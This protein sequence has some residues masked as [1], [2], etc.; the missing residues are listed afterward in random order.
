MS[1]PTREDILR[2]LELLPVWRPRDAMLNES[3]NAH[4]VAPKNN[5]IPNTPEL[6]AADVVTE[7]TES[8][9][10]NQQL[11]PIKSDELSP[12]ITLP[13][14]ADVL[15]VPDRADVIESMD[16]LTLQNSIKHCDACALSET[17]TQIVFGTGDLKAEWMFIGDAPSEIDGLRGEPF[18]DQAG[19][20]LDNML[21][22]MQ[23]RRGQNVYITNVLK[24]RPSGNL[25]PKANEV[26]QCLPYLK[27]QV[28]LVK[29]K[30]IIALGQFAAQSLLQTVDSLSSLR[31]R[32][33]RYN[34]IPLIVTFHPLDLLSRL[35]DKPK[36]WDDLCLA[37]QTMQAQQTIQD[38]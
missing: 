12:E 2:E 10:I 4:P 19:K 27:Q 3:A 17:P 20:L 8:L 18:V 1:S 21:I 9:E 24:C 16:W 13:L 14:M 11:V 30:I 34:D 29:P 38:L 6:N 28:A 22:A 37:L 5:D 32:V 35:E 33:H 36:A 23:L 26:Q 25:D 15:K 7:A 31:G